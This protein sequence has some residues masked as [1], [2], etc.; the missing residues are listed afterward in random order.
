MW[1]FL[2]DDPRDLLYVLVQESTPLLNAV[3]CL[4][5]E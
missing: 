3:V 2:G 1:G 4:I 5:K